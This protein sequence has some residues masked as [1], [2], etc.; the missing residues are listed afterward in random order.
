ML[1]CLLEQARSME[2][3]VERACD[4]SS[5]A[6]VLVMQ[7]VTDVIRGEK[8]IDRLKEL[9]TERLYKEKRFLPNFQKNDYL[10]I[11][12]SIDDVADEIEIVG[13]QFQI[14]SFDFPKGVMMD[15]IGL[16]KAVNNTIKR[17]SDQLTF[18]FKDFSRSNVS[19]ERTQA[20][21]RGAR[22]ISW[23]LHQA[24]LAADISHK[25]LL[26]QRALV[27]TLIS[28]ADKAE[29]FSDSINALAIKYLTLD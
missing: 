17:L 9:F 7:L 15:F 28:V 8:E 26:M 11:C 1:A 21:R 12:E 18:L 4:G 22:E 29:R 25:D 16:A 5:E 2:D 27:K 6:R 13:R 23:S 14:Y 3:L 10:F 20:E 24:I 19:W